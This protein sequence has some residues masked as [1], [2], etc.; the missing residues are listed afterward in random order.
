MSTVASRTLA[1]RTQAFRTLDGSTVNLERTAIGTALGTDVLFPDSAG[2]SDARAIWNAMIE[3]RPAAIVRCRDRDR[4]D[5]GG[6][7][8]RARTACCSA[9]AAAATTSP[10]TRVADGGL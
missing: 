8:R 7:L 6:P 3:R 5:Q 1:P 9:C 4:R 2:Y 10:A